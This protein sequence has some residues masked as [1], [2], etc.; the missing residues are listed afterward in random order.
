MEKEDENEN[1][2]SEN[3]EKLIHE[4][5]IIKFD[6]V[7]VRKKSNISK[8]YNLYKFD[9][10]DFAPKK[11]LND[12]PEHSPKLEKLLK[13]IQELDKKDLAKHGTLFKHFIFSDLK[14]S[15]A[16]VKLLTSALIANEKVLAYNAKMISSNTKD[17]E[18]K[19]DEEKKDSDDND[20][21]TKYGKLQFLSDEELL[22]NPFEN[23]YLLCS[24]GV[25]NQS[26]S[27]ANKKSILTKFNQ[28]PENIHGELVRFIIMDSGYK[29]GIDLFDI[30]YVHIFEPSI[31]KSDEKQ[32][33][34]RGTRTCGQKGLDFHPT[35]GWPLHVFVYD[36]VIPYALQGSFMDTKTTIELYLKSMNLD[37]RLFNFAHDLEKTSVFGAIDYE[38]NKN[39]HLFSIPNDD[40]E[41]V[42]PPDSEFIYGGADDTDNKKIKFKIRK[43]L[44]PI[45]ARSSVTVPPNTPM[46]PS[47]SNLLIQPPHLDM[48]F[49]E[50]RKYIREHYSDYEWEPVKMENKCQ[51]KQTGGAGNIIKY[52]PTQDFVRHFFTPENPL[53][54]LL[55][56]H[57]VGTGKTATAIATATSSFEKQGYT[58]LWVTRTTLKSDIWKNMFEQVSN[59]DIRER[60]RNE[61]LVI[62]DDNKKR[63]KLLSKSWRIRPMSYKQ[64]SNL[65]SKQNALY[66]SLVKING[67]IDPLRKTLIVIDEAHKL[68]GGADLSSIERPDM[69][70]LH[71]ALMNSYQIS[72]KDSVK[73]LLMTATPITQN[74][75]ELIQIV[76]L[77]KLPDQQLP[78]D[79]ADFSEKFLD[80]DGK[81]TDAGR[82]KYL[83]AINGHISYLN[84]EKDARQFAQPII[85]NIQVPMVKNEKN[86]EKFDKHMVRKYFDSDIVD[87]KQKIEEKSKELE[88]ELEDL[89]PN[90]FKYLE[91]KCDDVENPKLQ[92]ACEKTV[93]ENI[94]L[95]VGEAKSE[96]IR[97]KENIKELREQM[98]N[99]NLLKTTKLS[100]IKENIERYAPAYDE[101]K[102]SLYNTLRTEC[103]TVVKSQSNLR[104]ELKEHPSVVKLDE[105]LEHLN[106]RIEELQNDLKND[107]E[108]H[109]KRIKQIRD[110]SKQDL[111]TLEKQVL[112]LVIKDENKTMKN[113]M[114]LKN[115][116]TAHSI[117][118]IKK[119]IKKTQK[120]R[121]KTYKKI[122]NTLKRVITI[123]RREEK[124]IRQAELKLRKTLREQGE[125]ED[126]IKEGL[127][128]DLGDKYSAKID[129]DLEKIKSD[130]MANEHAIIEKK[131]KAMADKQ[132]KKDDREHLKKQKKLEKEE[133]RK[134]QKALKEV[135]K[136]EAK[137][138]K[139]MARKTKKNQLK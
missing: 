8:S 74:P 26:I 5:N 20:N 39:I 69:N 110:L 40:D 77:C 124:K 125:Y 101:F 128:K 70:A 111:N 131:Q 10:P 126:E 136:Q 11:L 52:T 59:E 3:L 12:I 28:R 65:V 106:K 48:N 43:D 73:L 57:S 100:E 85:H 119:S 130:F 92:K 103:G 107:M 123:E 129:T 105:K 50:M 88:G 23:L 115:K 96:V 38:L 84:R 86:L 133:L 34:G 138:A 81:F 87:L 6:P 58:I 19:D 134:T 98:K 32:V 14:S 66:T 9:S 112:R 33:I 95:L 4:E 82:D 7:C 44:S 13:N 78:P 67:E 64:F 89:D 55:L 35:Q 117:E 24:T 18:E 71:Q 99:R 21:D 61:N 127:L 60:I 27:V 121:E 72:G 17:E 108:N 47:I 132:K 46:N 135:K 116:E 49:P 16:G 25:Y 51:E 63:M 29:E 36:L 97:I 120:K 139:K 68:Y 102:S 15:S 41:E 137:E 118:K 42:L 62:P 54:G 113:K 83:D 90:Q 75:M 93:R 94:R 104:T 30:K 56:W 2:L 122:R 80:S 37:V 79:F 53:K 22:Q 45:V 31:L 1:K 109:K 114:K 76:N 91:K